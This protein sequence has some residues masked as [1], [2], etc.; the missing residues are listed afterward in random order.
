L[1]YD[2]VE[3]IHGSQKPLTMSTQSSWLGGKT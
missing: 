2:N 1:V 3:N